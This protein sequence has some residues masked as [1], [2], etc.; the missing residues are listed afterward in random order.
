MPRYT[1]W[2]RR[3]LRSAYSI[4]WGFACA[5]TFKVVNA[6]DGGIGGSGK[7][8][9]VTEVVLEVILNASS[10]DPDTSGSRPLRGRSGADYASAAPP[11]M[12]LLRDSGGALWL[13]EDDLATLRLRLPKRSATGRFRTYHGKRYCPLTAIPGVSASVEDSTQRLLMTAPA[14]AFSLT[15]VSGRS[16]TPPTITPAVP[17][18][19]LNYQFSGERLDEHAFG[20][21]YAELGLFAA[22]GVL[23]NTAV[24]RFGEDGQAF[25]RLDTTFTRDFSDSLQTLNVGDAISDPGSFGN[26]VRFG[27]VKFS[28][29][30]NLRP[31][32]LTMPMLN[33][34]GTAAVPSLVDV[35][36]N[37][38]L[39]SSQSLPTGPF[40]IDRLPAVSGA[41][42]VSILV[43]DVL[44]REQILTR[45]FYASTSLLA[46]DLSQYSFEAGK[47]RENYTLSSDRYGSFIAEGTYRQGL[48]D[49][50]TLEGHAESLTKEAHAAG[51]SGAI[52]VRHLGVLNLTAAEGGNSLGRGWLSGVGFEHRGRIFSVVLNDSYATEH[53]RQVGDSALASGHFRQRLLF[54]TGLSLG[55]AGSVALAFA[56]LTYDSQPSQQT[57][58]LSH[59]ITTGRFGMVSLNI[60]RSRGA[61]NATSAFLIFTMPLD[62][63][64]TFSATAQDGNDPGEQ[65]GV[66]ATV[67]QSPPVGIGSGYRL[68]GSS[69]GYYDAQWRQQF[70][71]GEIELEGAR[72]AGTSGQRVEV[73][74][75][76]TLLAGQLAASRSVSESFAVIDAGGLP[77]VPIYVDHQRVATTDES[78]EALLYNLRPYEANRVGI[79]PLDLPIDTQIIAPEILVTPPNRSGVL[80]RLPVTKVRPGT[81]RLVRETGEPVP[82]GASV[83]FNGEGVRVMLDGFVYVTS[84]DHEIRSEAVWPGGR[85]R[86]RV[87]PPPPG[88]P[89]P[90]MGIIVCHERAPNSVVRAGTD[91]EAP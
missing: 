26:A 77:G 13:A 82:I 78:G 35:F 16:P 74:G 90:D 80:V 72:N 66:I 55:R 11:T 20:G 2:N 23:T 87:G 5:F 62:G 49:W 45:S 86:F 71:A 44:G 8:D 22:P 12:I 6:S 83:N 14:E 69:M 1:R 38:Q 51:L 47:L 32:L 48:T 24:A 88:E 15:N 9:D 64:R 21:S 41:G 63:Y 37:N 19:F 3:T 79:D 57:L 7:T 75:A 58:S 42:D 50:L 18:A 73:S 68:S 60:S 29:N 61:D 4:C 46:S 56:R 54:Q 39:A 84:F 17:G 31:D 43:R 91:P 65:P 70:T 67:T 76:V 34:G 52:G 25:T 30:F 85:C 81:F 28:R 40:L 89:M 59:S 53:F 10:D 27:G 36:I 33:A